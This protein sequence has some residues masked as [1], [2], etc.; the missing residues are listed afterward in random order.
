MSF[1]KVS[2][3]FFF[4]ATRPLANPSAKS[5]LRDSAADPQLPSGTAAPAKEAREGHQGTAGSTAHLPP[6]TQ[7][8]STRA[9]GRSEEISAAPQA[10]RYLFQDAWDS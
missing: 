4:F 1:A 6:A 2:L 10:C 5:A 7:P 3:F 9:G 8:P